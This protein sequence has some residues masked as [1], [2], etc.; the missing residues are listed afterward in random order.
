[1]EAASIFPMEEALAATLFNSFDVELDL[2]KQRF[3]ELKEASYFG[4]SSLLVISGTFL[5]LEG[6]RDFGEM[7]PDCDCSSGFES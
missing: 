3:L 2:L 6:G 4:V 1:M 7:E 5:E